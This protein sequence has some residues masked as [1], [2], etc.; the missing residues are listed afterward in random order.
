MPAHLLPG[1]TWL[2]RGALPCGPSAPAPRVRPQRW[3]VAVLRAGASRTGSWGPRVRKSSFPAVVTVLQATR[4]SRSPGTPPVP[5][6]A[7][8]AAFPGRHPP[9]GARGRRAP[10]RVQ[11]TAWARAGAVAWPGWLPGS[12]CCGPR[13]RP[14]SPQFSRLGFSCSQCGGTAACSPEQKLGVV[15]GGSGQW[16]GSRMKMS[17]G[18][19]GRAVDRHGRVFGGLSERPHFGSLDRAE[20]E[21]PGSEFSP[22]MGRS[23]ACFGARTFFPFLRIN[24][25]ALRCE[26]IN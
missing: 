22:C 19:R 12:A 2:L 11:V 13:C 20:K 6:P 1:R 5:V 18:E 7:C 3:L 25:P 16:D 8:G 9:P 14:V 24:Y 17:L 10:R 26:R 21:T 15:A 4:R 23:F